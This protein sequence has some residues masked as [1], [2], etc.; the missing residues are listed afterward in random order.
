[1][2]K[3]NGE[4][5]SIGEKRTAVISTRHKR[6]EEKEVSSEEKFSN[7]LADI[8]EGYF[9]V[10]LEG[11]FTFL[12]DSV[13]KVLGYSK[14][15]LLGND[16]RNFTDREDVEKVSQAYKTVYKTQSPVKNFHWYITGKDKTRRY[17]EGNIS[18]R[19]DLLGK[20]VGFRVIA[21][22]F[23]ERRQV[24]E[25]L[26]QSE[27]K[28]RAIL[29]NIEEGY[30]EVD[31]AGNFTFFNDSVCRILGYSREELI[32]MN[33][34]QY[35]DKEHSEKLFKAFNKVFNTGG[36]SKGFDWQIIRKD[37]ARR[38][39]EASVSLK[40]D[41]SNK[42]MGFRGIIHDITER[43]QIEEK[44]RDEEQRFRAFAEQ[45]S[46]IILLVDKEGIITYVNPA[47]RILGIN[48][49]E[50]TGSD[51]FERV[52]PDDI[53]LVTDSFNELFGNAKAPI[54]KAEIRIRHS[55]GDWFTF[56]VI[57]SNLVRNNIVEAAIVNLRDITERKVAED[58]LQKTLENLRKSYGITIKVLIAAVE[59]RDP[60]TAG[61]QSRSADIARVIAREMGLSGD[62][63]DGIRMAGSI[64]DIGK[65]SVPSEILSRPTKLTNIEFSMIKEHARSGYEMLKNV[66]SPWPLA[67]IIYQ[68][69]ERMDGSGY[70]RNLKGD[71]IILE[72]RIMAVSDVVEAMSSHRP[73]RASLGIEAALEEIE[74]NKG[75]LYDQDVVDA[76]LR[77]FREKGYHIIKVQ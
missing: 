69:H 34:R 45:S 70:P 29:E 30:Y 61:H 62:I 17:I 22:D 68:H 14:T 49:D 1:M 43:K 28:Y 39:I 31:L 8:E 18:L 25:S 73:Y 6:S 47:V 10:D 9:E 72:A 21:N 16:S 48:V 15:E 50:R 41:S 36:S 58:K 33:N 13:C 59:M 4:K 7:L 35:T 65:L 40:R 66:E 46:D 53:K 57:G 27:E 56:E 2:K 20:P 11:K 71:E 75:I 37:G 24:Q 19:K 77:L 32:G 26:S 51:V 60:Y 42:P 67:E 76:C 63:I 54:K 74:N 5:I 64:H 38:Y 44:L 55:N 12:N 23:T 52:H 3:K